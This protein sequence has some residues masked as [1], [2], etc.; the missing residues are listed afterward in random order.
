MYNKIYIL[1]LI[2]SILVEKKYDCSQ[3]WGLQK[4]AVLCSLKWVVWSYLFEAHIEAGHGGRNRIAYAVNSKYKNVNIE[5]RNTYIYF[6]KLWEPCQQKKK[7]CQK[8]ELTIKPTII[9]TEMNSCSQLDLI[10]VQANSDNDYKC[11]TVYRDHLT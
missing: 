9:R 11:I 7:K 1:L 8:K 5:D 3:V 4:N 6:F 10:E 2:L